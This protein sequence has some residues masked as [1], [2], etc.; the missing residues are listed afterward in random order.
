LVLKAWIQQPFQV[1]SVCPSSTYLTEAI[2]DRHCIRSANVV[3]ELGP[4]AGDTT[5]ALL[6]RMGPNSR[7]LAI[8]KSPELAE[9]TREIDDPRLTTV[10]G[11][12]SELIDILA[13]QNISCVDVVVSGIPFSALPTG[14][15]KRIT[16]SIHHV[17]SPGGT[18]IAYQL[19]EDIRSFARPLFGPAKTQSVAFNL[20]PLQVYSWT[21]IINDQA[22]TASI[23]INT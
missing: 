8:E 22:E 23:A 12:A 21:K 17:L 3:V 10:H 7:L 19:R 4:G 5:L 6:K 11:D 18:F 16:R 15:A 13:Q 9:A 20:P 1:A 14:T 2:A